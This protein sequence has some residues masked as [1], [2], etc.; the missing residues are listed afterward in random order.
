MK[1]IYKYRLENLSSQ[2]I[3]MPVEAEILSV[4]TQNDIP[5]IWALIDPRA[6]LEKVT[7]EIIGTGYEI[8]NVIDGVEVDRKY[9]GTF[10]LSMLV[11]HC[12]IASS[13]KINFK[14]NI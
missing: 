5:C 7:F 4:Q 14:K 6:A 13:P 8:P 10:Q 11:F 1:K 3:E 2:E 9:V 12:F